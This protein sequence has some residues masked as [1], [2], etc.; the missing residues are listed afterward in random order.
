MIVNVVGYFNRQCGLSNNARSIAS[1]LERHGVTVCRIA[2]KKQFFHDVEFTSDAPQGN[3]TIWCVNATELINN[4]EFTPEYSPGNVGVFMWELEFNLPT[5]FHLAATKMTELWTQ[6]DFLARICAGYRL[7]RIPMWID[8]HIQYPDSYPKDPRFTV[9]YTFDCASIWR[10]KNPQATIA[11]FRQAFPNGENVRLIMK[12]NRPD[13][14]FFNDLTRSSHGMPV[15]W[16]TENLP[17]AEYWKMLRSVDCYLSLHRSEGI[18]LTIAEAI[19]VGIPVIATGY[20]GNVDFC[21]KRCGVVVPFTMVPNDQKHGPYPKGAMWAE[22][23]VDAAADA[24]RWMYHDRQYHSSLIVGCR[25]VWNEK[26][27]PDR[28]AK[29]MLE[30]LA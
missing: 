25:D 10:R 19:S 15:H 3:V 7:A 26:L 24:L 21:D 12:V 29:A 20:G 2:A 1:L 18:G 6:T 11:A 9:L 22:P 16:L 14:R 4:G 27:H 30:R 5:H 23:D 28:A 13:K 17:R 8:E